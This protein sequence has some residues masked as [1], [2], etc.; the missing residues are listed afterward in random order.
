MTR[1]NV[2][3]LAAKAA[4]AALLL[5]AALFP[6]LP[7]YTDKGMPYRFVCYPISALLV[8]AVWAAMR[9]RRSGSGPYPALLDL[10][11]V[12]PFLLDMASNTADLFDRVTWWDDFMHVLNWIPWVMAFGLI[13]RERVP[14]RLNVAAL[15]VGFGAVTH[16]LWELG[17][18]LTFVQ[19][20]ASEAV[21]AYRDTIGDLM[22][23]LC[24]GVI[25]AT[26]LTTVLW[27]VGRRSVPAVSGGQ[28]HRMPTD[29][30]TRT[31]SNAGR[32]R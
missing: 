23:S 22:F 19:D 17:E 12:A 20:N 5:H 13:V 21:S 29:V 10:C 9:R 27:N 3:N 11:V 28:T 18:Y 2:V 31:P 4:L 16:I 6:H 1:L 26:A 30:G 8:P 25:G 24:G 15:T 32:G 14:G 7:Q